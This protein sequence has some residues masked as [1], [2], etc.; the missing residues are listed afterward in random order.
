[1]VKL[2]VDAKDGK[3]N[4]Q[5][6]CLHELPCCE[7][8]QHM[9]MQPELRMAPLSPIPHQALVWYWLKEV[10]LETE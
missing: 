10:G 2:F 5:L 1:M 8:S 6:V 7:E 4:F 3:T 9:E